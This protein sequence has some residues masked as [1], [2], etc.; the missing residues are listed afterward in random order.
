M[1]NVRIIQPEKCNNFNLSNK[2][3]LLASAPK[4]YLYNVMLS[5][6]HKAGLPCAIFSRHYAGNNQGSVIN[7][8]FNGKTDMRTQDSF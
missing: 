2:K 6:V 4:N 7:F 1:Y 8:S 3:Q 5:I